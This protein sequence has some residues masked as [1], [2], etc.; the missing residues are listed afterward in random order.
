MNTMSAA[1]V[2]IVDD[3]PIDVMMQKRVLE[4]TGSFAQVYSVPDGQDAL[5]I[6]QNY[7]ESRQK[8]PEKFPLLL[9]LLDIN[10]PRVSGFDFLEQ[11]ATLGILDDPRFIVMLSSSSAD[12]DRRRAAANPLVDLYL[13]K[14]LTKAN[15]EM[16][17]LRY[18]DKAD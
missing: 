4:R 5:A 11:Y 6:Y 18:I 3:D 9:V 13:V 8:D 1:S 14:P 16:L 7:E 10:M 15:A 2:L 12:E 17:A